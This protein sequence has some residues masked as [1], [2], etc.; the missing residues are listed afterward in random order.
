[1]LELHSAEKILTNEDE[2][3]FAKLLENIY[4]RHAGV[5]VTMARGAYELREAV[6][7]GK[8]G[9]HGKADFDEMQHMHEFLDRFYMSRIGIR[10]LIGQYLCLRQPPEANFVGMINNKVR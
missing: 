5:L 9:E 10:V 4:E 2:E 7:K 3:E 6:T 1:M 8:Y